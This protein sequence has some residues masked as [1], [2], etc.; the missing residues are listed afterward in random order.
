[1]TTMTMVMMTTIMVMI[2]IMLT[3]MMMMTMTTTMTMMVAVVG[4]AET[5]SMRTTS[6]VC[7]V[8]HAK[9]KILPVAHS[10]RLV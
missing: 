7:A 5:A 6:S 8:P 10:I 2:M 3:I 1:M 4:A 9:R